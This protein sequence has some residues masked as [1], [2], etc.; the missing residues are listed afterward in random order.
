MPGRILGMRGCAGRKEVQPWHPSRV[1][2]RGCEARADRGDRPPENVAV[3]AIPAGDGRVGH[4]DIQ[5]RK[6]VRILGQTQ[7]PCLGKLDG[8]AVPVEWSVPRPKQRELRLIRS[9]ARTRKDAHSLYL[10]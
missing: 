10:V 9:A 1:G 7:V 4:S 5:Q 3:L 6:E 2:I 8:N